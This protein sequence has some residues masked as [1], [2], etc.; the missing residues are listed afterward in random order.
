MLEA[1][2]DWGRGE[3]RK[4]YEKAIQTR[5]QGSVWEGMWGVENLGKEEMKGRCTRQAKTDHRKTQ[6]KKQG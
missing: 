4:E 3:D 1:N 2:R 5:I 6:S